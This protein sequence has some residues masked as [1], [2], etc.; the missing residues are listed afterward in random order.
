MPLSSNLCLPLKKY[1][2]FCIFESTLLQF[3][4]RRQMALLFHQLSYSKFEIQDRAF[5]LLNLAEAWPRKGHGVN[6]KLFIGLRF[7]WRMQ[8]HGKLTDFFDWSKLGAWS[9]N[10]P[11]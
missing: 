3:R 11:T 4:D 8:G 2:H 1:F 5:G 9:L 6:L 10:A 7:M